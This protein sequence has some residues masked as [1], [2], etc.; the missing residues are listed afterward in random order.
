MTILVLPGPSGF[1]PDFRTEGHFGIRRGAHPLFGDFGFGSESDSCDN[2]TPSTGVLLPSCCVFKECQGVSSVTEGIRLLLRYRESGLASN[3]HLFVSSVLGNHYGKITGVNSGKDP[4][5][6]SCFRVFCRMGFS[7]PV[8]FFYLNHS[9]RL[10]G[11]GFRVGTIFGNALPERRAFIR[12]SDERRQRGKCRNGK[13]NR[14]SHRA[15]GLY[16]RAISFGL[17][18]KALVAILLG[19]SSQ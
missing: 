5:L 4:C 1:H 12:G 7:Q 2:R 16:G 18:G 8:F 10:D 19:L 17:D 9:R 11:V 14:C 3:F 13:C 6:L 15:S